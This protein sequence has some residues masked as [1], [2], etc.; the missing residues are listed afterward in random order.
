MNRK[1]RYPLFLALW[2]ASS[3]VAGQTAKITG[4][5][6]GV[7]VR[8]S[9]FDSSGSAGTTREWAVLPTAASIGLTP[10]D[11]GQRVAFSAVKPGYYVVVL[12][13]GQPDGPPK[14]ATHVLSI[15]PGTAPPSDDP[16]P[17]PPPVDLST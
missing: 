12:V 6:T 4:P 1:L 10:F 14:V 5:A 2:L 3:A 17:L 13:V 9:V 15:E 8:P 16:P 7:P 11:D